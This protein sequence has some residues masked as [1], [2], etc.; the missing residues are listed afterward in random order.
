MFKKAPLIRTIHLGIKMSSSEAARNDLDDA[1]A[2]YSNFKSNIVEIAM[3]TVRVSPQIINSAQEKLEDALQNLNR[4]H[5]IW[6]SRSEFSA[7][8][9]AT[10]R[11]SQEWLENEWD[12]CF[13]IENKID[14]MLSAF[15]TVPLPLTKKQILQQYC[16]RMAT[17]KFDILTSIRRL[18]QLSIPLLHHDFTQLL[19]GVKVN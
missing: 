18:T 9:L 12:Q 4:T 10:Q 6:V 13:V 16:E 14:L 3:S 17:L 7:E 8:Q 15:S 11:Y 2:A 1:V 19:S 5:T